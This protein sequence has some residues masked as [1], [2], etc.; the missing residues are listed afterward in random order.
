MT[1]SRTAG[2]EHPIAFASPDRINSDKDFALVVFE[3][4][5]V[6]VIQSGNPEGAHKSSSH[7]HDLH[8]PGVPLGAEGVAPEGFGAGDGEE[9]EEDFG[10]SGSQ[11]SMMPTIVRSLG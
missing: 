7:L 2:R 10:G 5:Q 4:T 1:G 3:K 8:Q 11:W 6:H 9:L